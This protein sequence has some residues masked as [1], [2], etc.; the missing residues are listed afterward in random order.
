MPSPLKVSRVQRKGQVTIPHDL[1]ERHGIQEGEFVA[2]TE[3]EAG[4]L[5]TPLKI[6]PA[7]QMEQLKDNFSHIKDMVQRGDIPSGSASNLDPVSRGDV[8]RLRQRSKK[9]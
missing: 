1:R 7:E 2:F 9:Q 8:K 3:T 6:V 5:I 4:I